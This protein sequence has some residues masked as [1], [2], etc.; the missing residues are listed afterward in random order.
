MDSFT[1]NPRL[2]EQ[3]RQRLEKI[4]HQGTPSSAPHRKRWQQ[5]LTQAANAWVHWLTAGNAP[6]IQRAIVGETEIWRV[7][8]P[9]DQRT[10]YFD[11]EHEVRVWLDQRFNQ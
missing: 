6:R 8:D 1:H 5:L 3:Q 4:V 11:Q 9:V 2:I 7:Y 10:H